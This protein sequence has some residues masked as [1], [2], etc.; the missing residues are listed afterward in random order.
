MTLILFALGVCRSISFA[1]FIELLIYSD[2][3]FPISIA[4]QSVHAFNPATTGAPTPLLR[5]YRVRS[6]LITLSVS[7]FDVYDIRLGKLTVGPAKIPKTDGPSEAE[8][9]AV[10]ETRLHAMTFFSALGKRLSHLVRM[11]TLIKHAYTYRH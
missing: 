9:L 5:H 6:I 4:P 2:E 3:L 7:V 1:K 11:Q 10:N 8:A